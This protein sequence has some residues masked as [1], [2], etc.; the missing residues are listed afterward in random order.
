MQLVTKK[1]TIVNFKN[2][3][4]SSKTTLICCLNGKVL[5]AVVQAATSCFDFESGSDVV[6][7]QVTEADGVFWHVTRPIYHSDILVAHPWWD[8][9]RKC[10]SGRQ[11]ERGCVDEHLCCQQAV[12][13]LARSLAGD[14]VSDLVTG[15]VSSILQM[16]WCS[17]A[18][19]HYLFQA[20]LELEFRL[21]RLV[22]WGSWSEG[23]SGAAIPLPLRLASG[24]LQSV[25]GF[26]SE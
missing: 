18:S 26:G 5:A 14:A 15:P 1:K 7:F 17:R 8:R 9:S 6:C 19:F 11:S 23:L 10:S 24:S 2:I 16:S 12:T 25:S 3:N 4:E 13:C 22:V 21:V 20:N